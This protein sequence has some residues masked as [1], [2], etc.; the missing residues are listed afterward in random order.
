MKMNVSILVALA[1]VASLQGADPFDLPVWYSSSYGEFT[2]V[3]PR[4]GKALK[5]TEVKTIKDL[6]KIFVGAT[7]VTASQPL[8]LRAGDILPDEES[9]AQYKELYVFRD[10]EGLNPA[11][12]LKRNQEEQK[13]ESEEKRAKE[14]AEAKA[15][16]ADIAQTAVLMRGPGSA[17]LLAP[18]AIILGQSLDSSKNGRCG[19]L[20]RILCRS[21]EKNT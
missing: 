6:K 15:R 5:K 12:V 18:A 21:K 9:T 20:S 16:A 8:T 2:N 10:D 14:E 4:S 17:Q 7:Y 19:C 13:K 11:A 1:F 3:R